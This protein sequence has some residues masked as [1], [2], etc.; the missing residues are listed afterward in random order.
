M[1]NKNVAYN[2][3]LPAKLSTFCNL[4]IPLD[5]KRFCLVS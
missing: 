3:V 4:F 1:T 5:V 2:T